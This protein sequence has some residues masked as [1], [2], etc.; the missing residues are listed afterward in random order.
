MHWGGGTLTFLDHQQMDRLMNDTCQNFN[1]REDDSGEYSIEIDPRA[2]DNQTIKQL[3]E[4]GFNRISLGVQ[5]FDPAVQKSVNRIQSEAQTFAVLEAARKEGF[6]STSIDLIYGLPLQ[7]VTSF[8]VTL[9]KI[10]SVDPDRFSIFNY[11][12]LPTRFKTQRQMNEADMPSAEVKLNILQMII[13][14]LLEAGYI[15]IGMD[16]FAKPDDELAIAQR[17]NKLY[18]NFQGYSTHSDC[19]LIGLGITSIGRVA[20]RY[21]QNVKDLAAYDAAIKL[22]ALPVFKGLVLN[23][24][25]KLRCAVIT[26]LI[27]HFSLSFEQIEQQ[28]AIQFRDYFSDEL[29]VYIACK[30]MLY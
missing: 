30:K 12:H 4:L 10:L 2:T 21:I 3:R 22:G 26:Q 5:D 28:Y 29:T 23:D 13:Q 9:D 19:D 17:D 18:R 27:C 1:L 8:S 20:D 25:D 15:Y 7:T 14:R 16:H 6:R 24:D 11:A